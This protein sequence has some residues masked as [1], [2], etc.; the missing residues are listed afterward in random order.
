MKIDKH[1]LSVNHE[2]YSSKVGD[3]GVEVEVSGAFEREIP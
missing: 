3:L 1:W 2:W